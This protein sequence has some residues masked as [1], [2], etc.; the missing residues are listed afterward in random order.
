MSVPEAI[1]T[2]A[3]DTDDVDDGLNVALDDESFRE[4]REQLFHPP[5]Q[6]NDR[7]LWRIAAAVTI[8]LLVLLAFTAYRS[9]TFNRLLPDGWKSRPAVP[10]HVHLPFIPI[11]RFVS[12]P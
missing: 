11:H 10:G 2:A 3:A 1:P 9:G 6:K 7:R 12:T 5:E 4:H 8:L